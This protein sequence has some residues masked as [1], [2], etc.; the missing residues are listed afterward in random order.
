MRSL[1]TVF[2]LFFSITCYAQATG[3]VEII[4]PEGQSGTV[5]LDGRDTGKVA[6]TT[7]EGI[8]EGTHQ[9]QVRGDCTIGSTEILVTEGQQE[10]VELNLQSMGGFVEVEVTPANAKI[11]LDDRPIGTG[12]SIG[13]EIDCGRHVFE[14]RALHYTAE[15]HTI[16]IGMG[17]VER[18]VVDLEQAG[19]GKIS[20]SVSPEGADVFLDGTR[21]AGGSTT[22]ED[23]KE[24]SHLIGA[25]LEGYVPMETRV[26]VSSGQT[27]EVTLALE[28]EAKEAASEEVAT[29]PAPADNPPTESVPAET[30][31]TDERGAS[32][33]VESVESPE[34]AEPQVLELPQADAVAVLNAQ[35]RGR[36]SA[37]GSLVGVSL[38]TGY[39]SWRHWQ[40]VT[41]VRYENYVERYQDPT[42][43]SEKVQPAQMMSLGLGLVSGAALLGGSG[44]LFYGDN[45]TGFQFTGSF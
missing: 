40:G 5:Y 28:P 39:L 43:F 33:A 36:L 44:L 42:Y 7:L 13:M 22:L 21:V 14:F 10:R 30:Q 26:Q 25:L 2:G 34:A 23:V 15:E 11:F 9:L 29:A 3:E 17:N 24:G 38:V 37:G 35:R 6:P 45:G 8:T 1:L 27:S 4:L 12:P 19:T 32:A 16:E 20:V 18:L 41:M 31:E